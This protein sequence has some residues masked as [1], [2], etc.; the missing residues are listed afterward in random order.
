MNNHHLSTLH[1][2]ER[3]ASRK[4]VTRFTRSYGSRRSGRAKPKPKKTPLGRQ[5]AR[6]AMARSPYDELLLPLL[7][8]DLLDRAVTAYEQAEHETAT[9]TPV[10]PGKRAVVWRVVKQHKHADPNSDPGMRRFLAFIC[11]L[12]ERVNI[13][14]KV[15]C[16]RRT[17][18]GRAIGEDGEY[19]RKDQQAGL[20]QALACCTKTLQRYIAILVS[21]G[22]LEGA[23][24]PRKKGGLAPDEL[25]A[26][27]RGKKYAYTVYRF[28]SLPRSLVD[29]LRRFYKKTGQKPPPS[30]SSTTAPPPPRAPNVPE[31]VQHA[32]PDP[33]REALA[34]EFL[35][36]LKAR[37]A[38]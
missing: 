4:R 14:T 30:Q 23:H 28:K 24:Q 35:Q 12:L 1:A 8:R 20:A 25:P 37:P 21:A 32:P 19:V 17:W 3:Q 29:H 16:G 13:E 6:L 27:M 9:R 2:P 18:L 26:W 31:Q 10:K 11:K 36:K 38:S 7:E 5:I 22:I 34:W 15:T 33:E